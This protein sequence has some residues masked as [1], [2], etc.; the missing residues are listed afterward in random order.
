MSEATRQATFYIVFCRLRNAS[1]PG[2]TMRVV[3]TYISEPVLEPGECAV[4]V[5]VVVPDSAFDPPILDGGLFE[6]E[7][8]VRYEPE[9]HPHDH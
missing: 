1:H 4:R 5:T 3:R 8:V 2:S 7:H 6:A 9:E